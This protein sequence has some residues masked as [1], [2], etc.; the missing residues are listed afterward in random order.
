MRDTQWN[1]YFITVFIKEGGKMYCICTLLWSVRIIVH[2]GT[3]D[4]ELEKYGIS[5]FLFW[6]QRTSFITT[7]FSGAL[8]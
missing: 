6:L 3:G 2:E 7:H 5:S 4:W 1:V 8:A